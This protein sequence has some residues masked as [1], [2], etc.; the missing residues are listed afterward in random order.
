MNAPIKRTALRWSY[1]FGAFLF[2]M[3][4]LST[5]VAADTE[6]V[7][8]ELPKFHQVNT[9]L[10]RGAQPKEGGIARLAKLGIRTVISLRQENEGTHTEE[11]ETRAAGLR[12]FS[13]PMSDL[14]RPSDKDIT[15]VLSLINDPGNYPVFVHCNH[16]RDRTGTVI[17]CYR[18]SHDGW[19]LKQS[20]DEARR[21]GM[22]RLQF[23]MAG[24]I[25]DYG[26]Q[27][28][29]GRRP[30]VTTGQKSATDEHR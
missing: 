21:Y 8:E 7:Y 16:G 27:Y 13:V 6:M 4:I 11:A 20:M 3:V 28:E 9:G 12:Y 14:G 17:A 5:A 22:S 1:R 23:R 25:S 19:T 2:S 10:Y 18:I 29:K 26:R 15:R 30:P 24:Y